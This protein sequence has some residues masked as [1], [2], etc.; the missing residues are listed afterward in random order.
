MIFNFLF[1]QQLL[2]ISELKI[3]LEEIIWYLMIDIRFVRKIVNWISQTNFQLL[4]FVWSYKLCFK[5]KC[6]ALCEY[7]FVNANSVNTFRI[8]NMNKKWNDQRHHEMHFLNANSNF[9]R[10]NFEHPPHKKLITT[11]RLR[12]RKKATCSKWLIWTMLRDEKTGLGG[13][14]VGL[15]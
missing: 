8:K 2:L 4:Y 9:F 11:K 13:V 12:E 7:H 10:I 15:G 5:L 1:K 14:M 3:T 6:I